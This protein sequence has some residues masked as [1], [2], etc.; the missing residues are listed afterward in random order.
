MVREEREDVGSIDCGQNTV[1]S[2]GP[3]CGEGI[4]EEWVVDDVS[5]EDDSDA[6][7]TSRVDYRMSAV[8]ARKARILRYGVRRAEVGLGEW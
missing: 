7:G 5:C 3:A 8:G 2:Q 1:C 6:A 4:L